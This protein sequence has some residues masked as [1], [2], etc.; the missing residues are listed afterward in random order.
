M[1]FLHGHRTGLYCL[2]GSWHW[3]RILGI[4]PIIIGN[5]LCC[6]ITKSI[7]VVAGLLATAEWGS[8][9]LCSTLQ[10]GVDG[11]VHAVS[12]VWAEMDVAEQNGFLVIDAENSF[13][14]CSRVNILWSN[15]N[16][17]Q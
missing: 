16:L 15:H 1:I 17:R 10:A 3:E 12:A 8:Y 11:T 4:C 2:V 14:S 7:L 9:Q 6:S 13:N 5:F